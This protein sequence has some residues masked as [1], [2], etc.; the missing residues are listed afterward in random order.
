[1][2]KKKGSGIA[3]YIH[4][5]ISF[6]RNNDFSVSNENIE[7]LFI[8][9]NYEANPIHIG[10]VYRP[11]SGDILKFNETI[12]KLISGFKP[13]EKVI[14][15]GDFNINLFSNGKN[16][17]SFEDSVLC[18]G[19][20]PAISI[21][22]HAKP[23]CQMSCI[24]NILTNQ[25]DSLLQSGVIDTHIS[26]H[27]SLFLKFKT[28]EVSKARNPQ[29][30]L[31][32]RYDFSIENLDKLNKHLIENLSKVNCNADFQSFLSVYTQCIDTACKLSVT[33][34]SKRNRVQNPW[35]TSAIINSISKR[36]RLY[37]KWK[38]STSKTCSSGNPRLFEEYRKYRN[39]LSKIIKRCKQSYYENKFDATTGNLKKTWTI[40][41]QLRGKCRTS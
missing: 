41:N 32:S 8:T 6:T 1:M 25:P 28:A 24:D 29:P 26:H 5:S 3:M 20:I 38:Q 23:S 21:A 39:R 7:S 18:T 33:K 22:T 11:P 36:D 40:I 31:K 14:I 16:K 35:I 19:F 30:K 34:L 2:I 17:Q 9:V 27:R 15:M 13:K 10:T 12:L 4:E 37:K